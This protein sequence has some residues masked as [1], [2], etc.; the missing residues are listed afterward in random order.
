MKKIL[1]LLLLVTLASC[2]TQKA[3][4]DIEQKIS[5]EGSTADGATLGK[6]INDLITSSKTLKPEQKK[7]LEAIIAAN[8]AR[9]EK[10][11]NDSYKFRS[12]LIK[13]LLSGKPNKKEVA[14]LK[15]DIKK[16]EADRLKNTFDAIE[17]ISNIVSAHPEH[18]VY[19]KH[20]MSI[21]RLSK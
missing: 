3:E 6:T 9:A 2:A 21:D 10:L 11:A 1:P 13:E 19:I 5:Q 8:K 4:K 18:D 17:K 16:I 7:E 15:A 20:L 14:L 12:V